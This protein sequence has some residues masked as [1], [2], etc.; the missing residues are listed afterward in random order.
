VYLK[1]VATPP[2]LAK[3]AGAFANDAIQ[4]MLLIQGGRNVDPQVLTALA[5]ARLALATWNPEQADSVLRRT[6][7]EHPNSPLADRVW[8]ALGAVLDTLGQKREALELYQKLAQKFPESLLADRAQLRAAEIAEQL[9]DVEAARH[10]Y[11]LLL[12]N[13]PKS[14]YLE[15]AR[16][17]LRALGSS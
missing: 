3:G 9:G 5:R 13:Y 7:G 11:E 16:K 17:R 15:K 10:A 1:A 4:L 12:T 14:V 8:F 6:L 2:R